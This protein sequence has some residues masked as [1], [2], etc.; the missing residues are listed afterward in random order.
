[1]TRP[2]R[3]RP[4]GSLASRT[5]SPSCDVALRAMNRLQGLLFLLE[6]APDMKCAPRPVVG[7]ALEAV[8][9]ARD[10]ARDVQAR[11]SFAEVPAA[12]STR[13]PARRAGRTLCT[14]VAGVARV[15]GEDGT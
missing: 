12:I 5:F 8:G 2:S 13:A 1:M 11:P 3:Q 7:E 15:S 10:P 14:E 6:H 4:S 9:F